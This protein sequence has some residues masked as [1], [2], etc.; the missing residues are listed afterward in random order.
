M[1]VNRPA[2]GT[3]KFKATTDLTY[4]QD[5]P[6]D[7]P[8][9]MHMMTPFGVVAMITKFGYLYMFETTGANLIYRSKISEETIFATCKNT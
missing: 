4:T 9:S 1:E 2:E 8:V 3:Q 6:N 5:V 7:F